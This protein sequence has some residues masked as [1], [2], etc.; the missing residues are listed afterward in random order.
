M[1]TRSTTSRTGATTSR[2]GGAVAT[3]GREIRRTP[4]LKEYR[5][6]DAASGPGPL[7]TRRP[8]RPPPW[9]R[10][11][12]ASPPLLGRELDPPLSTCA[13]GGVT[14]ATATD[15]TRSGRGPAKVPETKFAS[16]PAKPWS[17]WADVKDAVDKSD[18]GK[19]KGKDKGK[20]KGK[21][22]GKDKGKA[23]NAGA[24][25]RARGGRMAPRSDKS[26]RY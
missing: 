18:A 7:A 19:G 22:K 1:T 15:R 25:A 21:G 8:A 23:A 6:A 9:P 13:A 16:I 24:P 11:S 10:P 5:R 17:V 2:G 3:A 4:R 12:P 26:A 20:G 14:K